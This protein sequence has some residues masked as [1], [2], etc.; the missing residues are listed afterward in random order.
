MSRIALMQPYLFPYLGS[1]SLIAS[2]DHYVVFDNV[3]YIRRGWMHRNRIH[4]PGGGWQ[5]IGVSVQRAPRD[6]AIHAVR[7]STSAD[8]RRALRDGIRGAY[9]GVAPHLD[10]LLDIVDTTCAPAH[11]TLADLSIH[12]LAVVCDALD[13]DFRPLRATRIGLRKAEEEPPWGWAIDACRKVGAHRYVNP[14][15]GADLY[16]EAVFRERGLQR[17]ILRPELV[18]YDRN[19]LAWEPGLSILDALAFETPSVVRAH[20]ERFELDPSADA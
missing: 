8:W 9:R 15:G 17:S 6:T 7:L 1:F 10:T 11:E 12:A 14:P 16:P 19:G 5:Y 18:P 3:Q 20:V 13:L 4:R 2:V